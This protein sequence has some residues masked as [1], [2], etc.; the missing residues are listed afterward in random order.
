MNRNI[1]SDSRVSQAPANPYRHM[2]KFYPN[3]G[4]P[5]FAQKVNRNAPCPCGKGKKAKQCCGNETRYFTPK[6]KY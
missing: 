1:P 4:R 6:T 5:I 3:E 2:L